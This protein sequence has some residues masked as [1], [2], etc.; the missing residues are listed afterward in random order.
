MKKVFTLLIFL[1]FLTY[2]L[3]YGNGLMGYELEWTLWT[4]M[5]NEQI[6]NQAAATIWSF[7]WLVNVLILGLWWLRIPEIRYWVVLYTDVDLL[8][9]LLFFLLMFLVGYPFFFE[10]FEWAWGGL[11]WAISA[12]L[13]GMLYLWLENPSREEVA[14]TY[15]SL[16]DHL[17]DLKELPSRKF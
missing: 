5:L 8:D 13:I 9:R 1:Y 10:P 16:E 14:Q 12:I 15:T 7:R 11:L 17:I 2:L 3:P 4:N 6:S